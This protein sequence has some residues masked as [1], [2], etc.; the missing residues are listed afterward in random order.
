MANGTIF[1]AQSLVN[2]IHDALQNVEQRIRQHAYLHAL[3]LIAGGLQRGVE[4]RR[5]LED[6]KPEAAFFTEQDGQRGAILVINL[7]DPS[8]NPAFAELWFLTF[9]AD[10]KFQIA[11]TPEDLQKGG[12][13]ELGKK[14]SSSK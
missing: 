14:Y 3:V 4:A 5:I 13:E 12:L 7:V 2:T 9:N 11:M 6:T 1:A 10:V 8:H